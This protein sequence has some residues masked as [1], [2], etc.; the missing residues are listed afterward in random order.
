MNS[1][2]TVSVVIPAKNAISTIRR[3]IDSVLKQKG[4]TCEIIV[5]DDGSNDGTGELIKDMYSSVKIIKT[6][7]LGVSNARNIGIENCSG[8]YIA[9]I[10]SDDEWMDNKLCEQIEYME[11]N[12]EYVLVA[13]IAEYVDNEGK[14]VGYGRKVCDGSAT[15]KLIHGN[16]IV[17]SSVVIRKIIIDKKKIR[18]NAWMTIGEDWDMW[19]RLSVYGKYKVFEKPMVRYTKYEYKKYKYQIVKESMNILVKNVEENTELVELIG[20]EMYIVYLIPVLAKMSW[21]KSNKQYKKLFIES[22]RYIKNQIITTCMIIKTN[23]I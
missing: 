17:T 15:K 19:L 8:E 20:S 11:K 14:C 18:F 6:M 22:V 10:D 2:R 3:C 23:I 13:S 21:M 5:I 7:G 9:F 12:K 16:F 1:I 4:V